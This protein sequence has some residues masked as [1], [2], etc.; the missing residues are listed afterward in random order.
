MLQDQQPS[1]QSKLTPT[2]STQFINIVRK[3]SKSDS[4]DKKHLNIE[5][6][7]EGVEFMPANP[8]ETY[9]LGGRVPKRLQKQYTL[10]E[11]K[12]AGV[13]S[14]NAE[15]SHSFETPEDS[16]EISSEPSTKDAAKPLKGVKNPTNIDS[17]SIPRYAGASSSVKAPNDEQLEDIPMRITIPKEKWKKGAVYK[18]NNCFYADD[19]EFLYKI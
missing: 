18:V 14:Q 17:F 16:D 19:G 3:Q 5:L 11:M 7:D 2:K 15:V 13:I 9:V 6:T 4:A 10:S 1:S 8:S 12:D